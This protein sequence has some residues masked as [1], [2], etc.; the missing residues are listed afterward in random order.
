MKCFDIQ[1]MAVAIIEIADFRRS[2]AHFSAAINGDGRI[3]PTLVTPFLTNEV[4]F[5]TNL[6][7]RW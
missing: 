5:L 2:N 6:A 1:A 7:A 4:A 3:S